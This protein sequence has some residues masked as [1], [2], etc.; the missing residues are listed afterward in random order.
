M[1]QYAA[2]Q[3]SKKKAKPFTCI[4]TAMVIRQVLVAS[5]QPF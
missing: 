3:M 5:Y 1:W 2:T 4:T